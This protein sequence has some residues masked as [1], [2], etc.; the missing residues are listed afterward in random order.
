MIMQKTLPQ[1]QLNKNGAEPTNA[2]QPAKAKKNGNKDIQRWTVENNKKLKGE[3]Q[4]YNHYG[5]PTEGK[6]N[7]WIDSTQSR[8]STSIHHGQGS[9]KKR[10]SLHLF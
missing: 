2:A 8:E 6:I 1:K 7:I 4:K 9:R 5:P 10:I 3:E